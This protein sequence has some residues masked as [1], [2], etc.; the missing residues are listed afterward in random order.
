PRLHADPGVGQGVERDPAAHVRAG[1]LVPHAGEDLGEGTHPRSPGPDY[2]DVVVVE[3]HDATSS[4]ASAMRCA[5]PGRP[6]ARAAAA[7]SAR[8]WPDKT[9]PSTEGSESSRSS[10]I[11]TAAPVRSR[12]R[13]F[14]S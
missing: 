2:V 14:S 9:S 6:M 1:D 8:R 5:A 7:I 4:I 13:A 12:N 11:T 10:E 3:S